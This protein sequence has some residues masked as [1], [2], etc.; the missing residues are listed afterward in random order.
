LPPEAGRVDLQKE[1]PGAKGPLRWRAHASPADYVDLA[2]LF[3]IQDPA[4]GYAVA[5]VRPAR[6]RR[7]VLSLGSNDGIKV[8]VN[9]KLVTDRAVSR[10][11]APG[12][13]RATCDL[14]AG[15]NELRVK[16]DNTGGP[17][18]FYLEVRDAA[19]DRPLAGLEYRTTPPEAKNK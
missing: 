13:D 14:T 16:V 10:S 18:G 8:W 5:W 4:V 7:V 2:E 19:T 9:G 17:W 1:Y 12:Q 15:W 6:A 11:A 3:K